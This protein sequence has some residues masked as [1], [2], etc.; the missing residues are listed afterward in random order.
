[1]RV[2]T[3]LPAGEKKLTFA[4]PSRVDAAHGCQTGVATSRV[5]PL[6]RLR[7]AALAIAPEPTLH[8]DI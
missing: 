7:S 8:R 1:M 4:S 2:R 5:S 6:L 3:Q